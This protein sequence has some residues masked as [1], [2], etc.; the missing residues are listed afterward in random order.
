MKTY[1]DIDDARADHQL[2][3]GFLLDLGGVY[4]VTDDSPAEHRTFESYRE[5]VDYA[6][7]LAEAGYD[8]TQMAP[9]HTRTV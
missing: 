2:S 9:Q 4:M 6:F 8:E 3:G 5:A 7:R 1:T